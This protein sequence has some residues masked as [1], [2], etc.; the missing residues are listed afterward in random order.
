[1][2][3]QPLSQQRRFYGVILRSVVTTPADNNFY[4]HR[5]HNSLEYNSLSLLEELSYRRNE[6]VHF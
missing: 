6:A 3:S 4:L 5:T 2:L 1:M